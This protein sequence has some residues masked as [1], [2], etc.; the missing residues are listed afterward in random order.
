M[1]EYIYENRTT[2]EDGRWTHWSV[3]ERPQELAHGGAV[4]CKT[5]FDDD[6]AMEWRR[7]EVEAETPVSFTLLEL[8]RLRWLVGSPLVAQASATDNGIMAK[9]FAAIEKVTE[10]ADK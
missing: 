3:S 9:I 2:H 7:R 1:P 5:I 4:Y 10:E 6:S 8:R